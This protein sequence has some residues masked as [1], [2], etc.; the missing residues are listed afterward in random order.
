VDAEPF[1]PLPQA[2]LRFHQQ[3][4]Q[5]LDPRGLFNPGRLYAGL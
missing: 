2:L 5:Q 3:L 4:K 1:T